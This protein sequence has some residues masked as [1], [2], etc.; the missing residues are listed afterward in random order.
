[1]ERLF[2][3]LFIRFI[4]LMFANA[5]VMFVLL[6]VAYVFKSEVFKIDLIKDFTINP[7]EIAKELKWAEDFYFYLVFTLGS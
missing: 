1:M 4:K 7:L 3:L 2:A 5:I 6:F